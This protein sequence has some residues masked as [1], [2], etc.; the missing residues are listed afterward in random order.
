MNE[1]GDQLFVKN[2]HS[3]ECVKLEN[4]LEYREELMR[5][6]NEHENSFRDIDIFQ[7]L[8]SA[9]QPVIES[10]ILIDRCAYLME[11]RLQPEIVTLFDA[12][13]SPRNLAIIAN[14]P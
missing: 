9:A 12:S 5:C 7:S 10:L 11:N 2:N 8:K 4:L 1:V 3:G 13:V 6:K 14:K